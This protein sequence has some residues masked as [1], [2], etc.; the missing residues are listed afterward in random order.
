MVL[1]YVLAH[2]EV[3]WL[4]TEQQKVDV[5]T[6]RF[7]IAPA[8][9]PQKLYSAARAGVPGTIRYFTHKLPVAIVGDPPVAYFSYLALDQRAVVF[10]QFLHDH[11][12]LFARLPIWTVVAVGTS[13][14]LLSAC[15]AVFHRDVRSL[16]SSFAVRRDDLRWYFEAR[17]SVEQGDVARFSVPDI[18]RFRRLREHFRRPS[19]EQQYGDWLARGV[20][21]F[22]EPEDLD[23]EPRP[24]RGRFMSELLRFDYSQF[25]SL[26]GV[27]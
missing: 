2:G 23:S 11:A 8:D 19:I 14:G 5:F 4:A 12:R 6:E 1:D 10:E 17:R 27:A 13:P 25:G 22:L 3:D 7:A 20:D 9:L 16:T 18:D 24:S 15:E 21:E 26:P